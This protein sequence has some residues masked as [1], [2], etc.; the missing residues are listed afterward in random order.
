MTTLRRGTAVLQ[1]LLAGCVAACVLP[2]AA[3]AVAP[4]GGQPSVSGTAR[5]GQTL[6]LAQGT[7]DNVPTSVTD[8]WQDCDP[9]GATCTPILT[10]TGSTYTLTT[11]DVGHTIVVE[12]TATNA[13]GSA[14][15]SSTPTAVVLPLAPVNTV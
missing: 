15:A 10:A 4:S 1:W 3:L 14:T 2:S 8:V 9:G 11:A 12:E 13:D 5:E 6:T 7:W